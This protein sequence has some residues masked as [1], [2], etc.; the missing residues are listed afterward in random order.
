MRRARILLRDGGVAIRRTLPDREARRALDAIESAFE[1]QSPLDSARARDLG[2]LRWLGKHS[3]PHEEGK[4]ALRSG[5]AVTQQVVQH[6]TP[7]RPVLEVPL[8]AL[9]RVFQA[10]I[11]S[12]GTVEPEEITL[13]TAL[14]ADFARGRGVSLLAGERCGLLPQPQDV[15]VTDA[16]AAL[17]RAGLT[18][19]ERRICL[20]SLLALAVVDKRLCP[21]ERD[22]LERARA[23]LKGT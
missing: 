12:D 23:V 22:L 15:D 10:M 16:L 4:F 17:E 7:L 6:Q 3:T 19:A 8:R 14:L 18:V 5:R 9:A 2:L 11:E 1:D 20:G 13:A 21:E